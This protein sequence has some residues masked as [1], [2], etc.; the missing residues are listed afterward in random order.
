MTNDEFCKIDTAFY[1]DVVDNIKQ[2]RLRSFTGEEL[3]E[4]VE[5][6]I[7]YTH[8][9]KSEAKLPWWEE[10]IKSLED[11]QRELRQQIRDNQ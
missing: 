5:A 6:A 1:G 4:Y 2:I 7:N 11:L 8:C 9:C 3:K 10:Q